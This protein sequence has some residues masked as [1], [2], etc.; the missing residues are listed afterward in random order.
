M[1]NMLI[2]NPEISFIIVATVITILIALSRLFLKCCPLLWKSTLISYIVFVIFMLLAQVYQHS[3]FAEIPLF[4]IPYR[5][6]GAILMVPGMLIYGF[7]IPGVIKPC[8]SDSDEFASCVISFLFYAI[9]IWGIMKL[10]K[11]SKEP[12][13]VETKQDNEAEK[14]TPTET[15]LKDQ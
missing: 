14:Q 4:G 10:I 6:L 8:P 13:T 5:T 9:V 3:S 7:L 2:D 15:N 11:K 12:R 1:N